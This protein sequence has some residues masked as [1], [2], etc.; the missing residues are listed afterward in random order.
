MR[1]KASIIIPALL[2]LAS[3]GSAQQNETERGE[4]EAADIEAAIMQ[5]RTTARAFI[6]IDPTDTF[7][8]QNAL[9]EARARQ[10][11]HVTAGRRAHAEAFDTAFIHTLRAVSP[12]VA[13][14]VESADSK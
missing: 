6:N 10:S 14:A 5:G 3:C 11:E 8:L 4:A 1:V 7:A 12:D 9:L 2:A 13:R